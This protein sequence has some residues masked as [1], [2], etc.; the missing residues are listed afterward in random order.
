MLKT[1]YVGNA[2]LVL[3]VV[4][5]IIFY[6]G[7][8]YHIENLMAHKNLIIGLA[9]NG[10]SW[11]HFKSII[12][13]GEYFD[14]NPSRFRSISHIFELFDHTQYSNLQRVFGYNY[15]LNIPSNLFYLF[16]SIFFLIQ[17]FKKQSYFFLGLIIIILSSTLFL[18]DLFFL[19]RPG[20]K[21]AIVFS[22]SLLYL[23]ENNRIKQNIKVYLFSFL[24]FLAIS[25]DEEF[26]YLFPFLSLYYI[27][28]NHSFI[29]QKELK[30]F[31]YL[32]IVILALFIYLTLFKNQSAYFNGI[33]YQKN[34]ANVIHTGVNFELFF[35][36]LIYLQDTFFFMIFGVNKKL[37]GFIF[38]FFILYINLKLTDKYYYFKIE[39]FIFIIFLII[40]YLIYQ[41][42]LELFGGNIV[43][44]SIGYYYGSTKIIIFILILCIYKFE[45]NQ[46]FK[47]TFN[48]NL[49]KI[50][51]FIICFIVT[52]S[53]LNN[54]H[55][56]HHLNNLMHYKFTNV[57]ELNQKISEL[58]QN[59]Q[60]NLV[61]DQLY[62]SKIDNMDK[63]EY[64]LSKLNINN[65]N[66]IELISRYNNMIPK[67]D[68]IE[69]ESFLF[70]DL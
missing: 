27:Y 63:I 59:I 23:A 15:V 14:N 44:R 53:N 68:L 36:Y 45:L 42:T 11:Q 49:K 3:T 25:C 55:N 47:H 6:E 43:L 61:L 29:S 31:I 32:N 35:D 64:L 7:N 1:E 50:Y 12:F 2:V 52:V 65:E 60:S 16:F 46:I 58:K 26:L 66:N 39:K 8:W 10:L 57:K 28:I 67:K 40:S 18:S 56:A 22:L 69:Y 19:L 4:L 17:L 62:I 41:T 9:D 13:N 37:V 30:E 38:L 21:I 24:L 51:G 20:K 5:F 70:K 33:S 54:F 34:L 48:N